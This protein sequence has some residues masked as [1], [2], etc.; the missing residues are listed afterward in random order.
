MSISSRRGPECVLCTVEWATEC[1]ETD[2]C[3]H[4]KTLFLDCM[5]HSFL[6]NEYL[7]QSFFYFAWEKGLNNSHWHIREV[8][9]ESYQKFESRQV[10]KSFM[11][12]LSCNSANI[13]LCTEG[14]WDTQKLYWPFAGFE[15][16]RTK[17]QR[18]IILAVSW[19]AISS[20]APHGN[21]RKHVLFPFYVWW[22]RKASKNDTEKK[23]THV[24]IHF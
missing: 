19:E 14:A 9:G 21:S 8:I 23:N 7:Y 12:I 15:L 3:V 18:N 20:L 5:V 24:P 10:D 13:Y 16:L 2:T 22:D 6:Q 1:M 17:S 4:V 11:L